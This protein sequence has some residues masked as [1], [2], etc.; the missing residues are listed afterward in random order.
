VLTKL[1]FALEQHVREHGGGVVLTDAGFVLSERPPTV[2][3]PDLAFVS[4]SRIPDAADRDGF[5]HFAPDLA[6]EVLSPSNSASD[7]HQKIMEYFSA[8]A[9]TVWVVDPRLRSVT[10]HDSASS[11]HFLVGDAALDG[12]SILPGFRLELSSLFAL[13]PSRSS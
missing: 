5:W 10:V 13:W 8:G 12:A 3:I 11:A 9:R 6:V 4:E 7:M 2:R 1:V